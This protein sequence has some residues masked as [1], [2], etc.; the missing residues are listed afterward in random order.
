[1]P[2]HYYNRRAKEYEEIYHRTDPVRQKELTKIAALM[3]DVLTNRRVLEIACGTGFWTA[4][5]AE[6]AEKVIALDIS[7]EMLA[8]AKTKDLPNEKVRFYTGDAY[9]LDLVDGTFNAGLANFWLSHVPKS[10]LN[11]FLQGLHRKLS[12]GAVVFMADNVYVPGIGGELIRKPGREDTFKLRELADG[13]R[14]EVLK[15]YHDAGQ[16][17][18]ILEP[19][20]SRLQINTGDCFWWLTYLVP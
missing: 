14:H 10:R 4:A 8:I 12:S 15:N 3:K 1:M 2:E 7:D 17:R 20:S 11:N 13:S 9:K 19:L 5:A 16:L 18:G 6:T